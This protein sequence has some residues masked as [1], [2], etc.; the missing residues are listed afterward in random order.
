[1][2]P[3][4]C[5]RAGFCSDEDSLVLEDEGEDGAVLLCKHGDKLRV[6]EMEI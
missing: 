6:L 1:M 5:T 4:A 2:P 3:V